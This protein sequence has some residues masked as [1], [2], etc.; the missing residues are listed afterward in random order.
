[1]FG[2][3]S[4]SLELC[5]LVMVLWNKNL[6]K[7]LQICQIK[8]MRFI[9]NLG[10]RSHISFSELDSLNMLNVE[11]RVKQLR[12]SHAYNFFNET[13]P[14]YFSEQFIKT[15]DIHHHFT[16][17]SSENFSVPSISVVAATT[18]YYS[19]IK[20][21]NSLPWMLNKE[22]L[23]VDSKVQENTAS[24]SSCNLWKRIISYIISSQN[25]CSFN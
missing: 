12:L 16:R 10:L 11:F 13:G 18:F 5:I 20:D 3:Y 19:A 4:M 22:V 15:S 23:S 14:S 25:I 17:R 7:N 8:T 2:T 9:T 1:M 21:W 24:E 6:E